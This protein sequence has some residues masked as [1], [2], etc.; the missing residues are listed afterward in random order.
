MAWAS[1]ARG[2]V[3]PVA[4]RSRWVAWCWWACSRKVV[5]N[6]F[7]LYRLKYRDGTH[8][9][10]AASLA[11]LCPEHT[12]MHERRHPA[13]PPPKNAKVTTSSVNN[14]NIIAF[15]VS[16]NRSVDTDRSHR[17]RRPRLCVSLPINVH[18]I[19]AAVVVPAVR[20]S[21]SQ[22][23]YCVHPNQ[24]DSRGTNS[25]IGA[26]TYS[27]RG[28]EMRCCC[29]SANDSFHCASQPTHRATAKMT[30]NISRGMP[31]AE[32]TMPE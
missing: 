6:S 4:S 14:H 18:M 20:C 27:C 9:S 21:S 3:P 11:A 30:V 1:A 22:L 13:P 10:L 29:A 23:Y 8:L 25:R 32:R 26:P 19:C 7:E 24:R 2:G 15:T 31:R 12:M 5:S 17:N 16:R 28:R